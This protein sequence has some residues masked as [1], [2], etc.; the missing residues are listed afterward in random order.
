MARPKGTKVEELEQD[1]TTTSEA[2]ETVNTLPVKDE[3]VASDKKSTVN[4][5]H[6]GKK[7]KYGKDSF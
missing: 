2:I 3:S 1:E 4:G 5:I 6:A 7:P